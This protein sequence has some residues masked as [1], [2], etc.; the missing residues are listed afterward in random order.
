MVLPSGGVYHRRYLYQYTYEL[1]R[2]ARDIV[3]SLRNCDDILFNFLIANATKQGP[4]VIDA[5]AKA[6]NFGGLWKRSTHMETRTLCLNK[7][8]EIFGGMPL[9]YTM[10]MFKID[11]SQT[12]PGRNKHIFQDKMPMK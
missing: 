4:V 6:Y 5:F 9:K 10:K 11:R 2:I 1:P 3:D 7:F 8:V 12:V